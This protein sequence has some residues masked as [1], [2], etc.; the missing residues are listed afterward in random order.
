MIQSIAWGTHISSLLWLLRESTP[1]RAN[2]ADDRGV[3]GNGRAPGA[4]VGLE[5][6]VDR[7]QILGCGVGAK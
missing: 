7:A 5:A 2:I 3:G 4:R 6:V 1:K